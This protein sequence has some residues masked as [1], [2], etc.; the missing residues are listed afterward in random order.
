MQNLDILLSC[1]F[2]NSERFR[3]FSLQFGTSWMEILSEN[4]LAE[5]VLSLGHLVL[6]TLQCTISSSGGTQE[7]CL[8]STIAHRFARNLVE[9][10]CYGCSDTPCAYS[11]RSEIECRSDMC[12]TAHVAFVE[13]L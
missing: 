6:L 10:S 13:H 9:D 7:R 1:Y 12:W 2:R 3:I 5:A 8:P 4:G 11:V